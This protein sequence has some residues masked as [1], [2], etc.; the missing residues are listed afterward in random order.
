MFEKV[1]CHPSTLAET[2]VLKAIHFNDKMSLR[3]FEASNKSASV[4]DFIDVQHNH[5]LNCMNC[6]GFVVHMIPPRRLIQQPADLM[7]V[8]AGNVEMPRVV[9]VLLRSVD[10]HLRSRLRARTP[11]L[12]YF[13]SGFFSPVLTR[14]H[15]ER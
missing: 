2:E 8:V 13:L 3:E 5:T 14:G 7:D 11:L 6:L 15:G 1:G 12:G 9:F 10:S 4:I